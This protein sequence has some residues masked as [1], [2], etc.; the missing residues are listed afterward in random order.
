MFYKYTSIINWIKIDLNGNLIQFKIDLHNWLHS[1][2]SGFNN[3]THKTY[4]H[5]YIYQ[6]ISGHY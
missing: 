3:I 6:L 4:T 1:Y 2:S 5:I